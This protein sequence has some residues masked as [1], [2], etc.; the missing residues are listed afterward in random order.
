[1]AGGEMGPL[2]TLDELL[3]FK[4]PLL[5]CSVEP[6]RDVK[7]GLPNDPK[8][9][10]CHDMM[11]GYHED[12]FVH[13]CSSHDCYRFHHWQMI[14]S[15]VYFSHYMVTI[16]PPGWIS[17]GHKHGVK[18]LGTFI[19]EAEPGTK[20]LNEIREGKLTSKVAS[21]L[22]LVAAT[23]N[24][25]GWLIN[26]ESKMDDSC[27]LFLKEFLEAVTSET[28]RAVPGSLVIWYDSV[29]L[30]GKLDWQ[31][32]LNDKNSCFFDLCDGIF[33]NYGWTEE[34]L[35]RSASLAGS[36]KS[37]VYVGIDVF[38][39]NTKYTGGYETY[40]AVKQARRNGLSSAIFAAGWVYET[41]GREKFVENQY[42]FWNFP[43]HCRSEWRLSTLPLCTSFCQGFGRNLYK[44]GKLVQR[45]PWFNLSEQ[46]L[47]PWDQGCSLCGGCGAAVVCTDQAY[48]G[49]SCLLLR[50]VPSA[51]KPDASPYFRL[52]ACDLPL[53]SL[54]V[55]YT[56]SP[57]VDRTTGVDIVLVLKVQ[58]SSG[59]EEQLM[60]GV[61][62][63]TPDDKRYEAK[64]VISDVPAPESSVG[65]ECAW[66]TRK[67][68]V[69]DL[70]TDHIAT[71]REVGVSFSFHEPT[72][73]GSCLLGELALK[74]P[75]GTSENVT[76]KKSSSNEGL[77]D[78][79]L[80]DGARSDG[81]EPHVKRQ[82]VQDGET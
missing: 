19:V 45:G 15:F 39:R 46:Q 82:R 26:I 62:I 18:V 10:F 68:L 78:S 51:I 13:G 33:L 56:F 38:A 48:N 3:I 47:Q 40:K 31:N 43:R 37:D 8:I 5:L 66:Q 4:E 12:R 74:R 21:Q 30:D 79:V 2:K 63:S 35:Q 53:G 64:L 20:V 9:L 22:A 25:D 41:Q 14:D 34:M 60:L 49:G 59:E 6:L 70:Q 54:S 52:F 32:E 73:A 16:P 55:S 76:A 28:H 50:F 17:A 57:D 1:M 7:R 67:Y 44:A 24:F 11:G 36:R 61:T 71:L 58:T 75:D 29:L 42:L 69:K 72:V 77:E 23:H 81:A 65:T 80:D 27:G